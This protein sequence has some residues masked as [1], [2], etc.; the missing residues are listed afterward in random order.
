MHT[1]TA[2]TLF[3]AAV[4]SLAH[5]EELKASDIPNACKAICGP[6]VTLTNTCDVNPDT[7][8]RRRA[9]ALR[10]QAHDEDDAATDDESDEVVEA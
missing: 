9:R 6:I 4:A 5:A 3:L 8:T 10:H 1:T 7:E 2:T